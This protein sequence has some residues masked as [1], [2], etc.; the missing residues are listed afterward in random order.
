MSD[1]RWTGRSP[2]R[3]PDRPSVR[4]TQDE[5]RQV[6]RDRDLLACATLGLLDDAHD[7]ACAAMW[8]RVQVRYAQLCPDSFGLV[9]DL[10]HLALSTSDLGAVTK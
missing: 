2:E 9:N 4:Q 1:R 3:T 7:S 10:R 6:A 5:R 8:R